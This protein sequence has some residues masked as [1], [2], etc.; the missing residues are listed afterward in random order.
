MPAW[1]AA[2]GG[3]LCPSQAVLEFQGLVDD[4]LHLE[5]QGIEEG[6]A[7][8]LLHPAMLLAQPTSHVEQ[9]LPVLMHG[10]LIFSPG[11]AW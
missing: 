4:D 2:G 11:T 1:I 8:S 5:Q 9:A 7:V 6:T 10:N 3:G